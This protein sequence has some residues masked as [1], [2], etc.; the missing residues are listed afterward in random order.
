M[1]APIRSP[2]PPR[3]TRLACE[4]LER[5]DN[6]AGNVTVSFNPTLGTWVVQG[7]NLDNAVRIEPNPG[8]PGEALM[9]GVNGTTLNSLPVISVPNVAQTGLLV[10]GGA[11]NDLIFIGNLTTTNDL[12]VNGD[13]GNDGVTLQGVTAR[14]VGIFGG[15][16]ADVVNI[17]GDAV[18]ANLRII[19]GTED[20]AVNTANGGAQVGS[21]AQLDGGAGNNTLLNLNIRA[22]S[23]Q[24]TNFPGFPPGPFLSPGLSRYVVGAGSPAAPRVTVYDLDGSVRSDF[25]AYDPNARVGVSVGRGDLTGDLVDDIVTAPGVGGGPHVR[26]L[27]GETLAPVAELF[28]FEPGFR[29]GCAVAAGDANGDGVNDLVVAAGPGGGPRVRVVDGTRL[30]QVGA[31]GQ[32]LPSALL[33]DFFAFDPSLRGGVSVAVSDRDGDGTGEV[34]TASGPGGPPLVR[35]WAIPS[36]TRLTELQAFDPSFTGGVSVAASGDVLAFGAGAGADPVVRVLRGGTVESQFLAFEPGFR[37]GV[38][39]AIADALGS[40]RPALV[41][42]AGPGGGPRV[43]VMRA[44]QEVVVPDYFAFE[45]TLRSG[46][47]VA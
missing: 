22:P 46:V 34:V 13:A 16:G 15:P 33:A 17:F 39:V 24:V 19:C 3:S 2:A 11:G 20:D 25:F 44:D 32:V 37:G 35:L 29:G 10:N 27:D 31:D 8:R 38:R 4:Q 41:L 5:R 43:K 9:T 6:P 1:T 45:G 47:F 7:D 30:G 26:V 12:I 18:T 36:V 23:V 40:T 42:G 21:A 14:G 28:A